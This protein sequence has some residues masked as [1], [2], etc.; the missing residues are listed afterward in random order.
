MTGRGVSPL[1][2]FGLVRSAWRV[3]EVALGH[4]GA[5][6]RDQGEHWQGV[7]T[8]TATVMRAARMS[9]RH[10]TAADWA[11]H[12]RAYLRDSAERA[13]LAADILRQRAD[14]LAAAEAEG[15]PPALPHAQEPVMEAEGLARPCNARLVRLVPA[16][17]P[18]PTARPVLLVAPRMGGAD[19]LTGAAAAALAAGL[20]VYAA[21][22][23]RCPVPGQTVADVIDALAAFAAEIARRHPDAPAPLVLG[24]GPGG[25][26]PL[27]LSA[28]HP[29]AAGAVLL[30][31]VALAPGRSSVGAAPLVAVAGMLSDLGGGMFDGATPSLASALDDPRGAWLRPLAGI[32]SEADR[33]GPRVVEA[34]RRGGGPAL[35]TGEEVRWAADAL[36]PGDRL[37]RNAA[38]LGLG[39]PLDLRVIA[40]P[41]VICI[42]PDDPVATPAEVLG[43]LERVYPDATAIRAAGQR[44][45]VLRHAEAGLGLVQAGRVNGLPALEA[46]AALAPGLYLMGVEAVEGR[47]DARRVELSLAP[48]AFDA[49]D[50]VVPDADPA[51]HAAAARALRMQAESCE[52]L[53]PALRAAIAPPMAEASRALHPLRLGN[54]AISSR[55]PWLGPVSTAAARIR[56]TRQPAAPDNPFV[57]VERMG[58]E[59]A[60][61]WLDL[62][63]AMRR[64]AV[65]TGFHAVWGAPW[66]RAFGAVAW[67][68]AVQEQA[69][70]APR[71]KAL[72]DSVRTRETAAE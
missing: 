30:D 45:V 41:V 68:K 22:F 2:P 36:P 65:E 34:A 43:W 59:L 32:L 3:N 15:T 72:G 20:P 13:V 6:A 46:V 47:G 44:V 52:A 37:A 71:A 24:Q 8:Q 48:C 18:A 35:M 51:P 61:N 39:R 11:G 62:G 28:A 10:A 1:D 49:L 56:E 66:I 31:M 16:A 57:W 67:P 40:A 33:A 14:A 26:L 4:A 64:A 12:W 29:G 38:V 21:G 17:A 9:G 5:I 60:G 23:G 55:N 27:V 50:G 69:S 63:A 25:W 19:G 7:F 54:A 42:R 58:F 70:E 53:A